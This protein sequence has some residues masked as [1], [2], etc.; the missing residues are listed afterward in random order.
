MGSVLEI[1]WDLGEEVVRKGEWV[2]GLAD[3]RKVSCGH[4]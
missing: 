3:M 1:G 2:V 4:C